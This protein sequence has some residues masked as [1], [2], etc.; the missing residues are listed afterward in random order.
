MNYENE[1]K[2]AM[3]NFQYLNNHT[4]HTNTNKQREI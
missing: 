4:F 2:N 3:K 1:I